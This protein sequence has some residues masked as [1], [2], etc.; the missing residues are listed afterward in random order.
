MIE[1]Q[2]S[3]VMD[4]LRQM[5]ERGLATVEVRETAERAF[6]AEVD[7]NMR[8]TVWMQGGCKSWYLDAN[9]RNSTLWPGTSW[10]FHQRTRR[11]D[12]ANYETTPAESPRPAE[13]VVAA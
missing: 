7:A 2:I 6:S 11:F 12:L 3:Y 13:E 8:G 5:D 4:C 10:S 1:S 9:G